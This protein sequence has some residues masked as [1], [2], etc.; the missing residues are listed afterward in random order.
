MR[1]AKAPRCPRTADQGRAART[2]AARDAIL[3]KSLKAA[4]D[5]VR[6]ALGPDV[7]TVFSA[8]P[9]T[10]PSSAGAR[11]RLCGAV[12]VQEEGYCPPNAR[13]RRR[14]CWNPPTERA[15]PAVWPLVIV[16]DGS[17]QDPLD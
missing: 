12:C 1:G 8:S 13:G 5:E 6:Q 2:K 7:S 16:T 15:G 9:M 11:T 14:R 4:V 3:L 10:P 17:N